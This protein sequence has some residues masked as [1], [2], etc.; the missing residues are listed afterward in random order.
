MKD[1]DVGMLKCGEKGVKFTIRFLLEIFVKIP[2]VK[3]CDIIKPFCSYCCID[4]I[5]FCYIASA[6]TKRDWLIHGHVALDKCNVAIPR[7]TSEQLLSALT[8]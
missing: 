6:K 8:S 7:A 2:H 4:E 5:L 3:M 1:E